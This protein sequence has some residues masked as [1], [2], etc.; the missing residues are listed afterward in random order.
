MHIVNDKVGTVP[1][2]VAYC[3]RTN[4]VKVHT[5]PDA[6]RPLGLAVGGWIGEPGIGP[7]GGMLLR[8][9]SNYYMQNTGAS[10]Y[11]TGEFPYPEMGFEQS[12]WGQWRADDPETTDYTGP[13]R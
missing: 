9:G 12:T 1:I 3:N 5:D 6:D 10:L 7:N 4:Y 2:T 13:S 11:D 8:L